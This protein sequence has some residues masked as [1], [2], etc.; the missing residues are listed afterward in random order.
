[1]N[2]LFLYVLISVIVVFGLEV[3]INEDVYFFYLVDVLLVF[4]Y[5]LLPKLLRIKLSEEN[6]LTSA[7]L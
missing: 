4:C 1:M 2:T 5:I 3:A 6:Q 7:F